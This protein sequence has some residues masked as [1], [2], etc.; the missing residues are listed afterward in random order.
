MESHRLL[1]VNTFFRAG[2]IWTGPRGHQHRLDYVCAP[3]E[4]FGCCSHV[5][6]IASIDLAPGTRADHEVFVATIDV[7]NFGRHSRDVHA[8][9]VREFRAPKYCATAF[10]DPGVISQFR[11]RLADF[12]PSADARGNVRLHAPEVAHAD[13]E[14]A[15]V[16]AL[17]KHKPLK[18]WIST[19][20]WMY[21][22]LIAPTRRAMY[23]CRRTTSKL[24]TRFVFVSWAVC[25][26]KS[27]RASC[28]RA[29]YWL[30]RWAL[31]GAAWTNI[32]AAI[33]KLE[34]LLQ[35]RLYALQ[36]LV[37][38]LLRRDRSVHIDECTRQAAAAARRGDGK[39]RWSMIRRLSGR[40]Q[41][42]PLPAVKALDGERI[43]TDP[44]E[45]NDRWTEHFAQLF[46]AGRKD[47]LDGLT[48]YPD[49]PCT[50]VSPED[51]RAQLGKLKNGKAPG[52]DGLPE[53]LRHGGHALAD[54]LHSLFD[55]IVAVRAVPIELRGGRLQHVWKWK[56]KGDMQVCA[57]S[58]GL[59]VAD[60]IAKLFVGTLQA[61]IQQSC[62][63]Y[64]PELQCGAAPG[65]GS[66]YANHFARSM[67]DYATHEKPL[68]LHVVP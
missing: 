4:H 23:A 44:W 30:S 35:H 18:P 8:G 28:S 38:L 22:R 19:E 2:H 65:L 42:R 1:A 10:N 13:A 9:T 15:C 33:T 59:L 68:H 12:R 53:L 3:V 63:E 7:S 17:S 14:A 62:I 64:V 27:P 54:M 37:R 36:A 56:R 61:A 21:V 39:A 25:V 6:T 57:N 11:S 66:Y 20:T 32:F 50:C 45:V 67:L 26:A 40:V 55:H 47:S 34:A 51:V 48:T 43:I 46:C 24:A 16:F 41:P 52:P 60:E 49:T 58:R 29:R 31:A 5:G